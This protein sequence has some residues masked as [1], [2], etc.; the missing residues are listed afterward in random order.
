MR[1]Y[2]Q[3]LPL[4]L[5]DKLFG[6]REQFGLKVQVD[7][8]DWIEWQRV[9]LEFYK[10]TQKTGLGKRVNDLGYEVL[11]QVDFNNKAVCEIGPGSLPHQ[12]FWSG[13]PLKFTAIDVKQE[14]LDVT[15]S[16]LECQSES[17]LLNEREA[18]KLPVEDNTFD[19][20][21]SFYS[22]E[23][24]YPLQSHL[25]EYHRVLKPGG[26]IVGAVPNEGGF[27][28]GLGRLLTS[29]R[30]VNKNTSVD[31]DKVICWEHPNFVD[32]IFQSMDQFFQK[33]S[34]ELVPFKFLPTYDLN[35]ISKFIYIK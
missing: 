5:R 24:L 12:P 3:L 21:I 35:L 25:Q 1:C 20:I 29:R 17:I 23:H 22:L 31:Y 14:F 16:K 28:W 27:L 11:K 8:P 26:L 34:I 32:D 10:E 6:K 19:I 7:D 2:A 30:W 18:T 4:Y 33:R 13:E 15:L 9:C